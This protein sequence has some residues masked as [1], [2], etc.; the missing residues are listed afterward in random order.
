M[1]L[2]TDWWLELHSTY[3]D[4]IRQ[5]L[6]LYTKYG[7]ST[8][9]ALPGSE[10]ATKELMEMALQFLCARYPHYFTLSNPPSHFHNHILNT[11]TDLKTTPPLFVLLHNVPEDFAIMIRDPETG[12]YS[13]RAGI[14]MSSLGW[15]LGT[16]IGKKL[17]EIHGPVPDYRE[18]MQF[19]M[20]RFFAK[21]PTDKP[22]QRGSWGL[23][24]DEPLYVP[25]EEAESLTADSGD[26]SHTIDRVHLRVDWQTLRRLP[27]S[28]AVVFNFKGL[29][30]PVTE[31]RTEP[32]IPSLL[33]KV[34]R[35]GKEN[36]KEYKHVEHTERVVLPAMEAYEREQRERGLIEGQ[37]EVHTL[38]ESPFFPGEFAFAFGSLMSV[39]FGT[40][41]CG[42]GW[43]KKWREQHGF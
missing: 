16:K 4:V 13:F 26:P 7:S 19:S 29:F 12:I 33:L 43:E 8:L 23:E 17:H 38:E 15:N 30:T 37:W 34:L 42:V 11:T 22:I 20:D 6:D 28:G 3:A 14:I 25:P 41:D 18:K 21:M 2:E 24:I 5:R 35:E 1:K 40:N 39:L 10:L 31:F 36:L 9:Q 32:Y 27:L